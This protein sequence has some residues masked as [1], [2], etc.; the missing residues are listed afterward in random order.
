MSRL[1]SK[2]GEFLSTECLLHT[3]PYFAQQA[4]RASI[5]LHGLKTNTVSLMQGEKPNT[6]LPPLGHIKKFQNLLK[7]IALMIEFVSK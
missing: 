4:G 6:I 3:T 5:L 2:A 1:S 7:S